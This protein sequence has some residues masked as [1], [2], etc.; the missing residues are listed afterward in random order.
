MQR[1]KTDNLPS[2]RP[3]TIHRKTSAEIISE[4]KSVLASGGTILNIEKSEKKLIEKNNFRRSLAA[5][6]NPTTDHAPSKTASFV[7]KRTGASG[8]TSISI[9]FKVSAV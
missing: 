4:A 9:Q 1:S 7:W 8:E 3:K 5:G 6:P 2:V